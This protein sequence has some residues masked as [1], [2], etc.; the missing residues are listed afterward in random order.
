MILPDVIISK[1]SLLD[2]FSFSALKEV[3]TENSMEK[4]HT[5]LRVQRANMELL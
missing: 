3:Y 5:D 4:M 1:R 2:K